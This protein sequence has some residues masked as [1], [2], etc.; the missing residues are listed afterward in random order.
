MKFLKELRRLMRERVKDT[1]Q[2]I[3]GPHG[4]AYGGILVRM[5]E[6]NISALLLRGNLQ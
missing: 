4:L 2:V 1:E 3:C 6:L 5:I